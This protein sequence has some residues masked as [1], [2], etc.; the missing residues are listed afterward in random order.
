MYYVP[1]EYD[2]LLPLSLSNRS[3]LLRCC[4]QGARTSVLKLAAAVQTLSHQL[5]SHVLPLNYL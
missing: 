5:L 2:V 1:V 4:C 3:K